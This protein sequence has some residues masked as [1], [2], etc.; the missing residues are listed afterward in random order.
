MI[1]HEYII[2][3]IKSSGAYEGNDV[4]ITVNELITLDHS[5]QPDE[6]IEATAE[7]NEIRISDKGIIIPKNYFE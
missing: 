6:I 4:D 2:E 3:L 1:H 7:I 5:I